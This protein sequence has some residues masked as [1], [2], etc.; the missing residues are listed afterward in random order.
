VTVRHN[1]IRPNLM[2]ALQMLKFSIRYGSHLDFTE[3]LSKDAELELLRDH[4]AGIS[5]C[6]K[7]LSAF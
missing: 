5:R 7:D 4:V 3:G 1:H 6:P 2:E